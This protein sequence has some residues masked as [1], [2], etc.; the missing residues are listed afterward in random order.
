MW[1]NILVVF[2]LV[3]MVIMFV[4][5]CLLNQLIKII[6]GK[7]IVISGKLQVDDDIGFVLYKNVEIGCVEQINCDQVKFMDELDN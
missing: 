5:G 1:N 4:V 6:D 2:V 3:V 7:I